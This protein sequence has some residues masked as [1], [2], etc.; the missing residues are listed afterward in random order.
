MIED[1]LQP[2][3][4]IHVTYVG[5]KQVPHRAGRILFASGAG[6]V[7]GFQGWRLAMYGFSLSLPWYATAAVMLT[8]LLLGFTIGATAGGK[9]YWLRGVF[10]GML[11]SLPTAFGAIWLGL[12]WVRHG[13]AVLVIG[14]VAGLL[15][16]LILHA[17]FPEPDMQEKGPT[18][19]RDR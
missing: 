14:V 9:G 11:F 15:I 10:L 4:L 8:H 6:I 12:K 16:A 19:F 17:A 13:V 18:L 2:R 5:P 7:F 1:V 3:H